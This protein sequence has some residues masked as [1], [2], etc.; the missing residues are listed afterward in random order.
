MNV[1]QAINT[2]QQDQG[3]T[4]GSRDCCHFVNHV[5]RCFTGRDF[6]PW[7]Y[8]GESAAQAIVDQHGGLGPTVCAVIGDPSDDYKPGD[9]VLIKV[10]EHELLGVK[11]LE[12]AA[13]VT[14]N[15]RVT[16]LPDRAI[17]QGW[18]VV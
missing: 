6:I 7:V 1:Y 10:G 13:A 18:S 11:L 17:H 9:P 4:Y 5:L 3:F 15:G 2:W 12:G 14:D 8:D 16:R